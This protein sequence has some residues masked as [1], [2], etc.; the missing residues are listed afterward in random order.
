MVAAEDYTGT[1]PNKT[2]YATAPRYLQQ[3]VDALKAA[4]YEVDTFNV[5]APPATPGRRL[6]YP[7][8]L[9]VLSHFDAVD[10]YTGDDYVPQE[11]AETNP[12]YLIERDRVHRLDGDRVVGAP[13]A[14]STCATTST[15][16]ARSCSTAATP[17]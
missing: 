13:R 1:S 12:R 6:K 10:Y 3:H 14:G 4:G 2:P 5:D 9:G 16:A 8:F 7:T 17:T 11:A 15:R